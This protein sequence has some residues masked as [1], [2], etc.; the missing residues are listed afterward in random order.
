ML[1]SSHHIISTDS[2]HYMF[3]I[4]KN[5]GIKIDALPHSFYT[6]NKLLPAVVITIHRKAHIILV[7][8]LYKNRY[9]YIQLIVRDS[10]IFQALK[11]QKYYAAATLLEV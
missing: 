3:Y 6:N 1:A 7:A 4:Y 10:Q 8:L 5:I 9:M 2:Y 11:K